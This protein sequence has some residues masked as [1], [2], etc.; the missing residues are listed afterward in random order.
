M[1]TNDISLLVR[2]VPSVALAILVNSRLVFINFLLRIRL[3]FVKLP[4]SRVS[5]KAKIQ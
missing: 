5:M 3:K 1:L 2:P 4:F